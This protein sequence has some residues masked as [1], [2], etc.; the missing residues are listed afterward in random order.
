MRLAPASTLPGLRGGPA[1]ERDIPRLVDALVPQSQGPRHG[2]EQ[3]RGEAVRR[4][5]T[6]RVLVILALRE[7]LVILCGDISLAFMNTP[8]PE[9]TRAFMQPPKRLYRDGAVVWRL[10]RALNGLRDVARLFL[11]YLT[12]V[13]VD[14]RGFMP[15]PPGPRFS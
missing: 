14:E 10:R 7:S 6:V 12:K 4:P 2:Q 8:M 1:H 9:G 13:L 3:V 11:E 5:C 15:M